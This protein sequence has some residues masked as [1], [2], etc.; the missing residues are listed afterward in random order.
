MEQ[1]VSLKILLERLSRLEKDMAEV[2]QFV[3]A[4]GPA[5]FRAAPMETP[6]NA[7]PVAT[8]WEVTT[9]GCFHLRCRGREIPPCRSRRGQSALKF[10]LTS[11]EHTASTERLIETF[12][13]QMDSVA[14]AHNLQMAVYTLRQSLRGCEPAGQGETILFRDNHYL[15]NPRLTISQDADAFRAACQHGQE[16]IAQG[17]LAETSAALEVARAL[18]QGDYFS[19]P[20]EEWASLPRR[21]LQDLWLAFLTQAGQLFSTREHWSQ[22]TAC[23]WDILTIDGTREDITRQLMRCYAGEGR[24]ADVKHTYRLCRESLHHELHLTPAPETR[25]LYHQLLDRLKPSGSH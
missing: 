17:C 18:Y 5:P 15:L 9:L 16:A 11:P 10:L 6:T 19:D 21:A 13:P 12:W 23:F 24:T 2:R 8:G 25:A 14:G 7:E 1:P 22:A 20:Y 3:V 4:T